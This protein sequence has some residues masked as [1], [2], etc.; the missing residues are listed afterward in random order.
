MGSGL[1]VVVAAEQK[2]Q[3]VLAAFAMQRFEQLR[4]PMDPSTSCLAHHDTAS[5]P[6]VTRFMALPTD[7]GSLGGRLDAAGSRPIG[8]GTIRF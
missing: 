3:R 1:F 8:W 7:G 2:L 5:A 6:N 4:W